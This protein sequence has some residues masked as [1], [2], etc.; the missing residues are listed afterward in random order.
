MRGLIVVAI[1]ALTGCAQLQNVTVDEIRS[2]DHKRQEG[3]MPLSIAQIQQAMYDYGSNCRD[4]S[5][6]RVNPSRS[7][8]ATYTQYMPGL[9]DM[10]ASVLIDLKEDSSGATQYMAYTYY[11]SWASRASEVVEIMSGKKQCDK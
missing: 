9:T 1:L 11:E 6:L 10:S 3:K 2:E 5:P 4:I 7:D 8:T